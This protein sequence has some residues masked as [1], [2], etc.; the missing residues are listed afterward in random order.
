MRALTKWILLMVVAVTG[1]SFAQQPDKPDTKLSLDE[2]LATALRNSPDVQVADAKV[3]GAQAELRRTRL[4][5]LQK[6]IES[7]AAIEAQQAAVGQAEVILKQTMKMVQTG[8]APTHESQKAEVQLAAARAQLAQAEATLNALT[9]TLPGGAAALAGEAAGGGQPGTAP[10]P[11]AWAGIPGPAG[12]PG[13]AGGG[14]AIGFHGGMAGSEVA[15][16]VPRG[17]FADRL[18]AALDAPIKVAP[19]KEKP[20]AEVLVPFRAAAKDVPFMFHLGEK[21]KEVVS[22]TLEGEVPLGAAF[23]ALE[24]VVPGLRCYVR[25]YGILVTEDGATGI[26][27]GMPLIDFWRSKG[28]AEK[29]GR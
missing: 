9:G 21:A 6:V 24:D 12:G 25:E 28:S 1:W 17:A 20:L 16:R 3:R 10:P 13:F 15:M 4:T 7:R 14:G 26:A 27:D 22:L 11:P 29:T 2:L 23:Q 18:R 8:H 19:A 5:V